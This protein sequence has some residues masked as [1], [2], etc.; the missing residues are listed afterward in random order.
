[1]MDDSSSSSEEGMSA[2]NRAAIVA[3]TTIN[4]NMA[5]VAS[6]GPPRPPSSSV[7]SIDHRKLPRGKRKSL[8]YDQ[9][10]YCIRRD[11][12]GPTPQFNDRQFEVMFRISRSR[13]DR[14]RN[15][16]G[17]SGDPFYVCPNVNA[18]GKPGMSLEA[19]LLLPL[20][21]L[22]YG[23]PP[24]VFSDYF[25][26]SFTHARKSYHKFNDTV[27]KIYAEEY[28]RAPDAEDL[29]NI[30]DFHELKHGKPGMLGSLDCSHSPWK[31]C[32][33]AW[34]QS[35][36]GAKKIPTIVLE[37]IS[38]QHLWFWHAA[39]GF[40][41]ALNDINI[42]NLSPL[43]ESWIDGSFAAVE[44]ESGRM[45]YRIHDE[46]FDQMYVLTDGIYPRYSRFVKAQPQPSTKAEKK[47]TKWQESARKDIE[48]AFGVLQGKCQAVCRPITMMDTGR[49]QNMISCSLIVHNWCVSDRVME[50]D[51]RARYN[52]MNTLESISTRV[53]HPSDYQAADP[54]DGTSTVGIANAIPS[55]QQY[56]A[57]G[58]RWRDLKNLAEYQRLNYALQLSMITKK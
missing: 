45:P 3:V 4:N 12:I 21:T 38:D 56:V 37:A 48:R 39:F 58:E 28:L 54:K 25:Q 29:K 55:V 40:S 35:F 46:S 19:K 49:I 44:L 17:N 7:D 6:L 27:T 36:Q 26:M 11:Y 50:G 42:F 24:H 43:K 32:P 14:L 20:K 8:R 1:M 33:V 10:L 41:G 31:N 9:A 18:A 2:F 51:V 57:S 13:F 47:F 22:A 15:D 5:A 34:Q 52:P 23:V 53:T 30:F 16:V